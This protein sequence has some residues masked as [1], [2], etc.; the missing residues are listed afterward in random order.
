M[1]GVS[2]LAAAVAAAPLLAEPVAPA[3]RPVV[4][5]IAES[6]LPT[7]G[8]R[9][10][11]LA[12]D[13]DPASS[14]TSDGDAKQG[15]HLTLTFD[16]PVT[17]HAV[18]ALVGRPGEGPAPTA[19][20]VSADGKTFT[21]APPVGEVSARA[22]R[23]R[24]T[25]DLNKPL[26]VREFTIRSEPQVVPFRY[27]VEFVLDVT[28]APELKAWGDKVV[29]VCEREYPDICTFLASDGYV[30]PTQLRMTLKNNYT[31]VAAA[32]GGRITGSVKYFKSRPDDIGAMVHET[33]HCVQQYKG[34]G[35]PGWLV[36]GIADYCRFWRYEPGKAGRL[37][38]EKAQYNGSYRTTAAFLAFVTDR[39]DRQA[40]PKLNAMCREGRY[41]P[42]AW[43]TLTGKDVE[44]LNQEW[45]ATLA[46]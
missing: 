45:R 39:Y 34:R 19:L 18:S 33:V 27:P 32:G 12:F 20:E 46:R 40:V 17:L 26:V 44:E 11:Q 10:R 13:G 2:M 37:T 31:G 16:R 24:A 36:E 38:P 14:F 7:S 3:P 1:R 42:A 8:S 5:A 21:A 35:N 4:R 41:T 28:D 9:I 15:D 29:R 22:V 23:V 6:T 25:A 43:R 30:P